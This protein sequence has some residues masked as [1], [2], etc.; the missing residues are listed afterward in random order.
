MS[1]FAVTYCYKNELLQIP[2]TFER[3]G[4][5]LL[6]KEWRHSI[7]PGREPVSTHGKKWRGVL[8]RVATAHKS[9]LDPFR[10]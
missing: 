2:G 8:R 4:L 7:S 1:R 3:E 6:A 10:C 5:G 9:V